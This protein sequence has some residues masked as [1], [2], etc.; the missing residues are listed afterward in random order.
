MNGHWTKKGAAG[1]RGLAAL[2]LFGLLP[3]L[4]PVQSG[5][6]ADIELGA[7]DTAVGNQRKVIFVPGWGYWAFYTDEAAEPVWS[8]SA[9]GSGGTWSA[10]ANVF[11]GSGADVGAVDYSGQPSVW[12]NT[13]SS[14]VFVAA[15]PSSSGEL[16]TADQKLHLRKGQ[17]GSDG[18]ITWLSYNNPDYDEGTFST[19]SDEDMVNQ[20]GISPATTITQN[21]NNY[22]WAA[23][24]GGEGTAGGNDDFTTL[25]GMSNSINNI[26]IA[27]SPRE[28]GGLEDDRIMAI[29]LV[30]PHGGANDQV[31]VFAP[32]GNGT[33]VLLY[34]VNETYTV[35]SVGT[36][37]ANLLTGMDDSKNVSAVVDSSGRMH[38]IGTTPGT[39]EMRYNSCSSANALSGEVALTAGYTAL[40]TS[41]GVA[42]YPS[43]SQAKL[44]V[45]FESLG[46]LYYVDSALFTPGNTPGSW[47][48]HVLFR[49]GAAKPS[50]AYEVSTPYPMPLIYTD[51]LGKVIFTRIPISANPDPTV[52]SI[53]PV[54]V[55]IGAGIEDASADATYDI[56]INGSGFLNNPAPGI[57]FERDGVPVDGVTVTS[58]TYVT[59]ASLSLHFTVAQSVSAGPMDLRVANYDAREAFK[60]GI[61]TV[62]VPSSLVW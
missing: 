56:A 34:R 3:V 52:S 40:Q 62:T 44:I 30:L 28:V 50:L 60:T 6:A 17:L 47:N 10:A 18:S 4:L 23:T 21:R 39:G 1:L 24:I 25:I 9:S 37:F 36:V 16:S 14:Y 27:N 13:V 54:T 8:F 45:V 42:Y 41:V 59:A 55:G 7:G 22:T 29:S 20:A 19:T 49:S 5:A 35:S 46:N 48:A 31:W 11:A 15:G 2:L 57:T 43:T 61:A 12:F 51:S 53:S 58:V 32:S 26:D 38:I 33:D